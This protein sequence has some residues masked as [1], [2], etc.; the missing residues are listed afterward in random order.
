MCEIFN[1]FVGGK[2]GSLTLTFGML[3][4]FIDARMNGTQKA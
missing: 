1:T 4:S 3:K 2:F